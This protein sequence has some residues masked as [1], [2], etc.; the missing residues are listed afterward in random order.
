MRTPDLDAQLDRLEL[1]CPASVSKLIH[2]LRKPR[3]RWWRLIL[4][5]VLLVGGLFSFL[6]VLGPELIPIGLMLIA[7][8]VPFLRGPV[9]RLVAWCERGVVAAI[10]LWQ[11]INA[12]LRPAQ[13]RDVDLRS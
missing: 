2:V 12:R 3:L 4:G 5:V 1:V 11:A 13:K 10:A 7:I 9:A 6:P 8:D